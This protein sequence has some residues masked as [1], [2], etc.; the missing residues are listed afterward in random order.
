MSAQ[1]VVLPNTRSRATLSTSLPIFS[2]R[3]TPSM[4]VMRWS[5]ILD[6]SGLGC[7]VMYS[8]MCHR[9]RRD[10]QASKMHNLDVAVVGY[11]IQTD[12]LFKSQHACAGLLLDEPNIGSPIPLGHSDPDLSQ[13]RPPFK[14]YKV[15]PTASVSPQGITN[16]VQYRLSQSPRIK[17]GDSRSIALPKVLLHERFEVELLLD[18]HAS[19][20]PPRPPTVEIF[21]H[22]P[23]TRKRNRNKRAEQE[24]KLT[25]LVMTWPWNYGSVHP[26]FHRVT[27]KTPPAGMAL[28]DRQRIA[29]ITGPVGIQPSTGKVQLG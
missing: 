17:R 8:G 1:S 12:S 5:S 11:S 16:A 20:T 25:M 27:G 15:I 2:S 24:E 22:H 9:T 19:G 28:P 10:L 4:P 29:S 18:N 26:V 3:V 23:V 21:K 14:G 7:V 13:D 6:H